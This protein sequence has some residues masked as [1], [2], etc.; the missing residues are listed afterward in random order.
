MASFHGKNGLVKLGALPGANAVAEVKKFSVKTSA[1]V[2][3]N[4][5]MGDDW[6]THITGQTINSWSGSLGCN[7]DQS[8]TLGQAALIVGASI[9]LNLYPEGAPSAAHYLTGTATI[10]EDDV[11]AENTSAVQRSFSF[12]GNGALTWAVLP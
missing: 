7:Y 1:K 9:V 8:N 6:E 12:Q 10:T 11:D 4:T 2:A 5:S 3:D